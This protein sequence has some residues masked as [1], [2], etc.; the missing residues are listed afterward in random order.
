MGPRLIVNADDLGLHPRI[1][2]GILAA[3][4]RGIVTSAT[5]L[6]T[7]RTAADAVARAQSQGLALGLHLCLS[8]GLPCAAPP[9]EVPRLAPGGRFRADWAAVA[10]AWATGGI[11]GGEV[12]RELEA[13]LARARALGLTP[14]HQI[15]RAHV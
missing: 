14:D 6:V 15:G 2:E 10:A 9:T 13:Q 11:P 7:G 12:A 3:H 8:T 1:D 5:A 4:A